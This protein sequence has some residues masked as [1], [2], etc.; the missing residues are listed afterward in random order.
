[1]NYQNDNG[2]GILLQNQ[3]YTIRFADSAD[4]DRLC[5]LFQSTS[6]TGGLSVQ[7]LR[8]QSPYD[9]F[10]A[11]G[12]DA[13]I[14][15]AIDRRADRLCAVGGA[16][17]RREYLHGAAEKCAYLTGLK[18]HPDYRK[19][20]PFLSKAYAF[21]HEAVADCR[22]CYTTILDDN[23]DA[24]SLLEK[25]HK[26]M[27]EY[28]YLGHYT[29]YC[30]H[31]GKKLLPLEKNNMDGFDELMKTYFSAMNL[32]PADYGYGGFGEKTFYA[33][34][35]N[36][37]IIACC[38]AGNQQATKQYKMCAYGG[39][40]RL[41]SKLPTRLL[42]Y[43]AFPKASA[44]INHGVISYLYIKDHDPDLGR[45]F[46]RSVAADTDFSLLIWGGFENNPLR[47][48]LDKMRTI[49]YGSRLYQV[50]WEDTPAPRGIIGVEAALL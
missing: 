32:A 26:N 46:L 49:R 20:F 40:Y 8:G 22:I 45:A 11:D 30:F 29:T 9:S 47:P 4:N 18:I 39:I 24:I 38:F 14:L 16:V 31:G 12:A 25:R 42:Q 3:T 50:L 35:E 43:P 1:M 37:R 2:T 7:Y 34:R 48:A 44:L 15:L 21:L 17:I 33:L 5:D 6:F 23:Q 27:P 10:L 36:G 41:V 28:R 13:R 19:K